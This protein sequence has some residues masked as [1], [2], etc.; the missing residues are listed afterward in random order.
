MLIFKL[1]VSYPLWASQRM[2]FVKMVY[3]TDTLMSHWISFS[4]QFIR[5]R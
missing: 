1:C 3:D 5:Y 2:Y 4:S